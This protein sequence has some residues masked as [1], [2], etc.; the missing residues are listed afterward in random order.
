MF[1]LFLWSLLSS[2]LVRLF[3]L[4]FVEVSFVLGILYRWWWCGRHFRREC[5]AARLSVMAGIDRGSFQGKYRVCFGGAR[6]MLLGGGGGISNPTPSRDVSR[7]WQHFL[8]TYEIVHCD[9]LDVVLPSLSTLFFGG[10]EGGGRA[11]REEAPVLCE[12]V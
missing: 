8:L 11:S 9:S 1:V 2:S 4:L 12:C 7:I 5:W 6:E 3:S 10:G